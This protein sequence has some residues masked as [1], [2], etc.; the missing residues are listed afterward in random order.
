MTDAEL[1]V[2]RQFAAHPARDWWP[3]MLVHATVEGSPSMYRLDGADDGLYKESWLLVHEHRIYDDTDDVT[4]IF[5]DLDDPAT[6]GIIWAMWCKTARSMLFSR[7][8][9]ALQQVQMIVA[10]RHNVNI[11]WPDALLFCDGIVAVRAWLS[12]QEAA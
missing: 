8:Q 1:V 4:D 12:V 5:P 2:A 3:G 9:G 11:A 6:I 10:S 7:R